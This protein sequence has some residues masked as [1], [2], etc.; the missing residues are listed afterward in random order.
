VLVG[1]DFARKL[2]RR[3]PQPGDTWYLDEVF[4]RIRGVLHY[5]WRAVDQHGVVLDILVQD[6]RNGTAAKRFFKRVAAQ[7]TST[8]I[9]KARAVGLPI[10]PSGTVPICASEHRLPREPQTFSSIGE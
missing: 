5:L 1:S 6:R 2:R 4:I 9:S 10:T 8:A 7:A 3:R